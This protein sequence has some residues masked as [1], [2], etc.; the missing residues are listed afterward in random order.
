M[1]T[2]KEARDLSLQKKQREFA[3]AVAWFEQHRLVPVIAHVDKKL[4][5]GEGSTT[6]DLEDV[7]EMM[8]GFEGTQWM[9]VGPYNKPGKPHYI[10]DWSDII[11]GLK[12]LGYVIRHS[13]SSNYYN[14]RIF[15]SLDDPDA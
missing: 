14:E 13:M 7:D 8:V 15:I 4:R 2:A 12:R 9:R 3:S 1:I 6:I 11:K 5:D 10:V